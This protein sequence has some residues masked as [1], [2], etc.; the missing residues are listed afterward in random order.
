ME[1]DMKSYVVLEQHFGDKQYWAGDTRELLEDDA[2][3][4][5]ALGLISESADSESEVDKD[6]SLGDSPKN[7]DEP[8]TPAGKES[9]SESKDNPDPE[10]NSK[11]G[12]N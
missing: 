9:E 7:K 12:K 10:G 3:D 1:V 6:K 11:D 5:I 4:L 2:A 8:V